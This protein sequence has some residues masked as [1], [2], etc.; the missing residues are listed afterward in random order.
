MQNMTE[1]A[2]VAVLLVDW[3][4]EL[5]KVLCCRTAAVASY[6]VAAPV[7]AATAMAFF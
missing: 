2:N 4:A 1:S 5:L 7:T 6:R 3:C